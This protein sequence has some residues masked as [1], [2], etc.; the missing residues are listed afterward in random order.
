MAVEIEENRAEM[1]SSP[2]SPGIKRTVHV[3]DAQSPIPWLLSAWYAAK[4]CKGMLASTWQGV[5]TLVCYGV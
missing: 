5:A 2:A 1:F 3:L 4:P